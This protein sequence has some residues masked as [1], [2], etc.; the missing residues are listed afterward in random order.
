MADELQ[1]KTVTDKMILLH[2]Q[3]YMSCPI[4]IRRIGDLFLWDVIYN[5][6]LYSSYVVMTPGKGQTELT[7]DQIEK[8]AGIALAGAMATIDMKK[9]V[10]MSKELKTVAKLN[11]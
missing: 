5:G 2:V 10:K 6:E 11:A 8:T 3:T 4:Y 1:G 9:G 7:K